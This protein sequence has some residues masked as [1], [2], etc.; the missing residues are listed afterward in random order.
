MLLAMHV[1]AGPGELGESG[2][3]YPAPAPAPKP[4]ARSALSRGRSRAASLTAALQRKDATPV[5]A[6]SSVANS[7]SLARRK[8]VFQPKAELANQRLSKSAT[9]GGSLGL[10]CLST[11]QTGSRA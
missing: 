4:L 3:V 6:Y 1:V 7:V 2:P 9:Q 10:A 8:P 5:K 11:A